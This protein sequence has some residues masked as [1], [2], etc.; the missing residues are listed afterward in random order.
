VR[1]RERC[2]D[3]RSVDYLKD[4]VQFGRPIASFQA[5][6]H[7]IADLLVSLEGMRAAAHYAGLAL[8]DSF[9][10]AAAAVSTAG[11]YVGDA[12]AALR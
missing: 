10:D 2:A 8:N 6:K 3:S 9:P 5:I 7:R 12:F 4:R 11:A 1:R